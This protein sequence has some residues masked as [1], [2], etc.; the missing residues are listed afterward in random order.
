VT[1]RTT[2]RLCA[3]RRPGRWAASVVGWDRMRDALFAAARPDRGSGPVAPDPPPSRWVSVD[4]TR[5]AGWVD[6][7]AARHGGSPR[8]GRDG[9]GRPVLT[10]P[11][12]GTAACDLVFDDASGYDDAPGLVAWVQRPHPYGLLLVRRGGWAVALAAGSQVG[13]SRVG[14]KYVQGQTK[15]GGWSQQRFAR[16]RAK[17]AE[18]LVG[19]AADAARELLAA[20]G[21]VVVTGGDRLLLRDTLAAVERAGTRLPVAGRRLDV[22]DPRRR[23]LDDAARAACAVRIKVVDPAGGPPVH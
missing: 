19:A 20:G 22:P 18:G 10:A 4:A 7:F 14:T 23:V 6:R 3:T 8:L 1:S 15:A 12:G 13:A 2:G 11:D 5:F 17:Q 9:E 16:R 21:R